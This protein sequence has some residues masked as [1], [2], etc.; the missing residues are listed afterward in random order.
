MAQEFIPRNRVK[1]ER[2][3]SINERA[4]IWTIEEVWGF[5]PQMD[6]THDEGRKEFEGRI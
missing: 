1:L 6:E 4:S 3:R 5:F 2:V